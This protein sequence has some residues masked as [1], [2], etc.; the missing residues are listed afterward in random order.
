MRFL[1][2][3]RPNFSMIRE[4]KAVFYIENLRR[5]AA[6]GFQY[7]LNECDKGLMGLS[8]HWAL[9]PMIRSRGN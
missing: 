1:S 7:R 4:G 6:G 8:A 5:I 3:E 2:R 9:N